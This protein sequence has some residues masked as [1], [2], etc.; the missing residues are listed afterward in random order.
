MLLIARGS[1]HRILF[2]CGDEQRVVQMA[3]RYAIAGLACVAVAMIG[4][5]TFA[6]DL[7]IGGALTGAVAGPTAAGALW[8]W[9][10]QPL[11]RRLTLHQRDDGHEEVVAFRPLAATR[12]WGSPVMT[13]TRRG[14]AG[15]AWACRR[16]PTIH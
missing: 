3:N 4:A 8:C 16:P 12:R 13:P 14:G 6:A 10:A 2:R 7:V 9:Y 1:H 5:L 15:R 11:R